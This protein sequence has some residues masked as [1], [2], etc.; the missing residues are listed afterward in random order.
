MV[1]HI[2]RHSIQF[3]SAICVLLIALNMR[4]SLVSLS[5]LIES[6]RSILDISVSQ[7]SIISSLPLVCFG[8]VGICVPRLSRVF[9]SGIIVFVAIFLIVIGCVL[10]CVAHYPIVFLGTVFLG[11]GIAILNVLLPG[12]IRELFSNHIQKMMGLYAVCIGLSATTGAF[13]AVPLTEG[14]GQWNA[15]F[16]F[17]GVLAALAL[18][19]WLILLSVRKS[20]LEKPSK[21]NIERVS[22]LRNPLA[23]MVTFT[24]GLQ[25]GLFYTLVAWLPAIL[26]DAGFSKLYAGNVLTLINIVSIFSRYLLPWLCTRFSSQS[27]IAPILTIGYAS[28]W[29]G[30]GF[31][32]KT[33]PLLWIILG[34][35][36]SG[37][38]L[39]YSLYIMMVRVRSYS[40]LISLSAMSQAI[41]YT[42]AAVWPWVIGQ[43][44][45]INGTWDIALYC[46]VGVALFQGIAAWFAGRNVFLSDEPTETPVK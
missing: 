23:W 10:R 4:G 31:F 40:Q 5:P 20:I 39:S 44:Y 9:S 17:W 18:I 16:I 13:I 29:I 28:V 15:A 24:M 21:V 36:A 46:L 1:I 19:L 11:S 42:I 14:T 7:F 26:A 35:M 30:F 3:F 34:G 25:S 45:S 6:L 8:L 33:Y 32:P 12:I 37:G 2:K 38:T 22:L 43:I 41:G 27:W